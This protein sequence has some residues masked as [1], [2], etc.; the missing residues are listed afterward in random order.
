[1]FDFWFSYELVVFLGQKRYGEFKEA[2]DKISVNASS[3]VSRDHPPTIEV[4][5][6]FD[7]CIRPDICSLL[8]LQSI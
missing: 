8:E 6:S 1:M 4:E 5:N 3:S 7:Y 2:L